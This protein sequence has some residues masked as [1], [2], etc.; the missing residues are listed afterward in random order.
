MRL[1]RS[2]RWV[3][4][5]MLLG[6]V[7]HGIDPSSAS[8]DLDD[9]CLSCFRFLNSI[10]WPASPEAVE[11]YRKSWNPLA[12]GPM[13]N[14]AIDIQPKGQTV[15]H[16]YFFAETGHQRFGNTFGT[17]K[18]TDSP[19]HL[20]ASFFLLPFEYGLTDSLEAI[21]AVS[22]I[23]WFATQQN[24]DSESTHNANG[25]GDTSFFLK[26]R[27]IVQDPDGWRPSI[28]FF[29]GVSLP[30]SQW[31]GTTPI[32]G[33]FAPIGRLPSTRFGDL[34]LTE[35]IMFRKNVRPFRIMGAVYYSYATPGNTAGQNKYTSD[36]VN[37]RL[38]FEH[39]L[40]DSQ[41]FGYLLEFVG[42]HGLAWR[43]DGHDVNVAAT[44]PVKGHPFS[45]SPTFSMIGIQP[46][47][48]YKFS[49]SIVFA[50]GVLFTPI[51]Q[52]QFNAIY[53]N[54]TIYY[55]WGSKGRPVMMR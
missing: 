32:P 4:A 13:L 41:G 6:I 28:T 55:Y 35:G 53:P 10:F 3:I 5:G 52:N 26:H 45:T 33:G 9:V 44:A 12:A 1:T 39:V 11:Q 43:A 46:S 24:F 17:G 40:D 20:N 7:T 29:H 31:M 22:W 2:W 19:F 21:A 14:P 34:S 36:L 38:I 49:N 16:P 27:P 54:F 48:E 51:G 23:D 15:I 25:P 47:I 50:A 37:W 8:A 30:T 18:L 42:L